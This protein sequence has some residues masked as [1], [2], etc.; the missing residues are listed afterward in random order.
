MRYSG[1]PANLVR[2][3]RLAPL[4]L[5]CA[6]ASAEPARPVLEPSSAEPMSEHADPVASYT[7]LAKLDPARLNAALKDT[8]LL[9]LVRTAKE[10][11][12]T[13]MGDRG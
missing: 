9:G 3:R 5:L 10:H 6:V 2:W 7:M 4:S 13:H 8:E 11:L 1:F 12:W